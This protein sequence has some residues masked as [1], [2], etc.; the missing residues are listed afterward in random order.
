MEPTHTRMAMEYPQALN[1]SK[2]LEHIFRLISYKNYVVFIK[3]TKHRRNKRKIQ[4][5][6]HCTFFRHF[7]SRGRRALFQ[8]IHPQ[9]ILGVFYCFFFFF[10]FITYNIRRKLK[11]VLFFL[12][13]GKV[14]IK[15]LS[16]ISYYNVALNVVLS[17][18]Y[19]SVPQRSQIGAFESF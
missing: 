1:N 4:I 5:L 2:V 13:F 9:G 7:V 14:K 6:D 18:F 3:D 12:H 16:N 11:A 10:F 17:S 15:T 19:R 8:S